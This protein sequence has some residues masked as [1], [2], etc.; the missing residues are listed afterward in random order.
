[1]LLSKIFSSSPSKDLKTFFIKDLC[2][3]VANY[4]IQVVITGNPVNSYLIY[5]KDK[6]HHGPVVATFSVKLLKLFRLRQRCS[7][8]QIFYSYWWYALLWPLANYKTQGAFVIIF[9]VC[10]NLLDCLRSVDTTVI[11]TERN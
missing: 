2:C 6:T 7:S 4:I 9:L 3:H 8:N 10:S 5:T 11:T 1:M